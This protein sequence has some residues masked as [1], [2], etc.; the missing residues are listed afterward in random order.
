M[1]IGPKKFSRQLLSKFGNVV[2]MLK[3]Y[4]LGML[5]GPEKIVRRIVFLFSFFSTKFKIATCYSQKLELLHRFVSKKQL[6]LDIMLITFW[7]DSDIRFLRGLHKKLVTVL[8]FS[9]I[10]VFWLL[11]LCGA[12]GNASFAPQANLVTYC[13]SAYIWIPIKTKLSQNFE[14]GSHDSGNVAL[15]WVS[16]PNTDMW[17]LLSF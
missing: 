1:H 5:T 17:L 16:L 12:G 10:N 7:S 6:T 4:L 15:V 3:C 9:I 14:G 13:Y 2:I 11:N 8:Y